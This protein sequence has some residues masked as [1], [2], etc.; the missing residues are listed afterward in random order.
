M[1]LSFEFAEQRPL[2]YVLTARAYAHDTYKVYNLSKT[3]FA[4]IKDFIK[5]KARFKIKH[6]LVY[7]HGT[8]C[9]VMFPTPVVSISAD[10]KK[11]DYYCGRACELNK[12]LCY[13]CRVCA[14]DLGFNIYVFGDQ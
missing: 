13:S 12:G 9:L 4:L 3:Q 2:K 7:F 6:R 11:F 5:Y 10:R 8:I 1:S 14:N